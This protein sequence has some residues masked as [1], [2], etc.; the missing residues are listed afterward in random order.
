MP[1]LFWKNKNKKTL[2]VVATPFKHE[3]EFENYIYGK[4]IGT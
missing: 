2:N 4:D 1:N 3:E